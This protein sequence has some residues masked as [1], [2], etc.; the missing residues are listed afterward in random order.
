MPLC[1]PDLRGW[2]SQPNPFSWA[3]DAFSFAPD[4]RRFDNGTPST[5]S[6]IASLPALEWRMKQDDAAFIAHNR[7]LSIILCD[8]LEA[9]GLTLAT[10]RDPDH[11]GG[12][13][14]VS[15][16]ASTPAAEVVEKLRAQE[17]YMDCRSQTLRMSPGPITTAAGVD[18]TL[19]ALQGLL[20]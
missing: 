19:A 2:F 5:L 16:P 12:S 10:P 13:L 15:L 4:A 14:M 18:R 7:Q 8:G 11:R 17:I 1:E 20:R 6:A 9:M 3:L